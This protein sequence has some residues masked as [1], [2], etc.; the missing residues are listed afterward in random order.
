[1]LTAVIGLAAVGAVIYAIGLEETTSAATRAGSGAKRAGSGL[2]NTVSTGAMAGVGGLAAGLQFGNDLFT[3][4]LADPGFS[5][6]A[7]TGILGGLGTG[8]YLGNLTGLQF[9]LIGLIAFVGVWAVTRG[10]GS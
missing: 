10:D 1:M 6:A 8:G 3:A 2:K 5:L 7:V 9:V 4:I